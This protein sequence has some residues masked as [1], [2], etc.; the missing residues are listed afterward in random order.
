MALMTVMR[1][2][3]HIFLWALL[4]M[5]LLSMTVGGLVGGANIIDQL[6]G[7]VDP[8]KAIAQ[9][10]G[11]NISPDRFNSI[12]NQQLETLRARNQEINDN[13]IG[14]ARQTAWD[15]M[16]QDILVSQEVEKLNILASDEEVLY[17]LE[18]SPPP[19]LTQNPSFQTDGKYDS[20]KFKNA[21]ANPQGDEWAPIELFM[22]N[23]YI[24]NFKLQKMLD[25]SIV[26]SE[27]ELKNEFT[28]RN[29]NY[30]IEGI[31]LSNNRFNS[32]ERITF[33]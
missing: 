21:L 8:S 26:I 12:V 2:K 24:P 11:E 17:Y 3:M 10:N 22:K 28:K 19:F 32:D 33:S 30:D 25:Q 5:F 14:R 16:L 9:V 7:K 27:Q 6:I 15:N 13:E 4:V 1:E 20:E 23:T 31:F 29:T 18:N